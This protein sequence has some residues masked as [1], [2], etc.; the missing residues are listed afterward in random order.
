MEGVTQTPLNVVQPS[1]S[2]VERSG[3]ESCHCA[4]ITR[5]CV[6]TS[7]SLHRIARGH[8]FAHG[9]AMKVLASLGNA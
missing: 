2:I 3:S 6:H 7:Q 1:P 4:D 9:A 5:L 8:E